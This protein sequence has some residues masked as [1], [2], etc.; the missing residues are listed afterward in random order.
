MN[1]ATEGLDMFLEKEGFFVQHTVLLITPL[2][3][4]CRYDFA[5]TK[6]YSVRAVFMANWVAMAMH[7]LFFAVSSRFFPYHLS[8]PS[9]SVVTYLIAHAFM[10]SFSSMSW[11]AA[12]GP[13]LPGECELLPLSL[14]GHGARV[15]NSAVVHALALLPHLLE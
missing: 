3:L 11:L 10:P 12:H 1:P 5:A 8:F 14:G 15:Q 9:V 2:Y 7:W 13:T 4:L 6:L